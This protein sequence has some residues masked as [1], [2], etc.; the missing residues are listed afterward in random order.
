M[1][2][3]IHGRINT[4]S[5]SFSADGV[6]LTRHSGAMIREII[7][8]FKI[9]VLGKTGIKRLIVCFYQKLTSTTYNFFDNVVKDKCKRFGK[10]RFEMGKQYT[11]DMFRCGFDQRINYVGYIING[12]WYF[13]SLPISAPIG[14]KRAVQNAAIVQ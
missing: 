6:Y 7:S 9:N 14:N 12:G 10:Q 11:T 4:N 13:V 3:T 8:D 1:L 5:P 2:F